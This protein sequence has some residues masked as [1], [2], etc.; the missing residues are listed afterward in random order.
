MCVRHTTQGCGVVQ[1]EDAEAAQAA[2]EV[3]NGSTL[4]NSLIVVQPEARAAPEHAAGKP[5]ARPTAAYASSSAA[6]P[7]WPPP[8]PR[9]ERR[10]LERSGLG[11]GP[12]RAAPGR[13]ERAAKRVSSNTHTP[14]NPKKRVLSCERLCWFSVYSTALAAEYR[15]TADSLSQH[16]SVLLTVVASVPSI[17]PSSLC[18]NLGGGSGR[19]SG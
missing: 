3:L 19:R 11:L 7:D 15:K 9:A 14:S 13:R 4:Q 17:Q 2:L 6:A 18:P 10:Q 12:G 8:P 16:G 1:M 5:R